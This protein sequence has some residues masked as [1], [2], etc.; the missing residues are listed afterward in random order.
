MWHDNQAALSTDLPWTPDQL[1]G[2]MA[3]LQKART[4]P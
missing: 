2:L 3:Y 4:Q 1:A